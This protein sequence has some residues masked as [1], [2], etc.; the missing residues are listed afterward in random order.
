MKKILSIFLLI[1]SFNFIF[2]DITNYIDGIRIKSSLRELENSLPEEEKK[3]LRFLREKF[4]DNRGLIISEIRENKVSEYSLL[5]SYGELMEYALLYN[6]KKLF[7]LLLGKVK[8]HFLSKE[9]YLYWRINRITLKVENATALIDSLR[10]LY[11]LIEAYEKFKAENY[12]K[13]A[14]LI[15]NGILK[16]NTF[17]DYF[18]DTYDANLNK[19]ILKISL[20]YIDLNRIRKI[21]LFFPEFEKFYLSSKN[22]LENYSKLHLPFFPDSYDLSNQIYIFKEPINMLEQTIIALNIEQKNNI[23][24]FLDF[25]KQILHKNGKIYISYDL[26]GR[27]ITDDEDPSVYSFLCRLYLKMN[28]KKDAT[29]MLNMISRFQKDEEGIGDYINKHYY[30]FTQLETLLTLNIVR[31]EL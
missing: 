5:E 20:F 27:K 31:R 6:H 19:Q 21:K 17:K 14:K 23:E 8:K 4:I 13:E 7:D 11:G 3:L 1:F 9:G 29:R 2:F 26:K 24:K 10:I 15:A 18:L 25:I 30:V 12:L 28:N 22:I 16:Y